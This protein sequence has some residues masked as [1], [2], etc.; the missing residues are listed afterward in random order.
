M[1]VQPGYCYIA[2]GDSHLT[3][4]KKSSGQIVIRTPKT[5]E[6]L[7]VPSV[8]VMMESV[9]AV[10]GKNTIGVLM[11]GIGDDGADQMVKIKKAGGHT[12]GESEESS[13]VYGMPR[14]A[15][16]RGGTCEVKPS[17]DIAKAILK[18]L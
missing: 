5:P 12:I 8:N 6:L 13:V 3:L 14:E 18:R 17:W 9:L 10:Y 4:Y 16:E 11:T 1:E 2:R 7:F 15:F